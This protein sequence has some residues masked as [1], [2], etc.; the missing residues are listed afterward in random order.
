MIYGI[1][2]ILDQEFRV[3]N[4]H[5]GGMALV[6]ILE[7]TRTGDKIAAKTIREELLSDASMVAR[8]R[9]EMKIWV[10]IGSHPNVVRAFFVKNIESCPFLFMEYMDKGSLLELTKSSDP[11]PISQ[12][13]TIARAIAEG[14][15]HVHNRLTPDG[16]RGIVHRDLKPSNILMNKEGEIKVADFGVARALDTTLLTRTLD[17]VGTIH[18]SSPEQILDSRNADKRADVYSFGA[19]LYHVACGTP[20]FEGTTWMHLVNKIRT[21]TP[22]SPTEVRSDIPEPFSRITMKCLAKQKEDRF[23]NF[24]EIILALSELISEKEEG[25][26]KADR[27]TARE[28]SR[29]LDLAEKEAV[30]N[31]CAFVEPVHLLLAVV[32][33]NTESLSAWLKDVRI[34]SD[35]LASRIRELIGRTE[36]APPPSDVTLKRSSRRVIGLAQ[37]LAEQEKLRNPCGRHILRA[38]IQ[39]TSVREILANGL[40][41]DGSEG[42]ETE[43]LF[44]EIEEGFEPPHIDDL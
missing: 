12:I 40:S 20:P 38:L 33:A 39:E 13:L 24:E 31:G 37:S 22:P 9:R 26:K 15:S 17:V 1:G 35:K 10:G 32:S 41:L 4:V 34:D 11:F 30:K 6:Y 42:V 23:E 2:H 8:F 19:I 14:M 44:D 7:D 18:Y 25:G 29:I 27:A 21:F 16:L 36:Q 5:E 3:V 43:T 28:L